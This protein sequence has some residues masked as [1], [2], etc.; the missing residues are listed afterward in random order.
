M[1][2]CDHS[3]VG[4]ATRM[5]DVNGNWQTPD[6]TDCGNPAFSV[7]AETVSQIGILQCFE[8]NCNPKGPEK[9]QTNF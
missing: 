3:A 4:Y 9:K 2:I 6:A 1:Y 5:C 8:L 7:L